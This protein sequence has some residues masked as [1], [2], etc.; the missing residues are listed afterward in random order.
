MTNITVITVYESAVP[1]FGGL[2]LAHTPR[3]HN[4]P[5]THYQRWAASSPVWRVPCPR[6]TSGT[7]AAHVHCRNPQ[8]SHVAP[9]QAPGHITASHGRFRA[10]RLLRPCPGKLPASSKQQPDD[11]STMAPHGDPTPHAQ[12][13]AAAR[14]TPHRCVSKGDHRT[15]REESHQV[16]P[17]TMEPPP[18]TPRD[19]PFP[20]PP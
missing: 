1:S 7:F 4:A 19:P 9:R 11:N 15:Q 8:S 14:Q 20:S 13:E 18:V 6:R 10:H 3:P 16:A 2:G 12:R 5:S 17:T